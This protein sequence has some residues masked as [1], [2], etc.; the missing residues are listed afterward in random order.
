MSKLSSG[1]GIAWASTT[2]N[3]IFVSPSYCATLALATSSISGTRS[4][5]TMREGAPLSASASVRSPVPAARSSTSDERFGRARRT[6]VFR[7]SRSRPMLEYLLN[8]SY[9][10]AIVEKMCLVRSSLGRAAS[11]VNRARVITQACLM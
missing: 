6:V 3:S 8:R 2:S 1:N 5:H 10:D 9:S 4:V 7:H 11:G